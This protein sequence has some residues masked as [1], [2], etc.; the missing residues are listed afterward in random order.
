MDMQ[1]DRMKGWFGRARINRRIWDQRS[2]V[3][4]GRRG[5]EGVCDV[6]LD[7]GK[8]GDM[9][10]EDAVSGIWKHDDRNSWGKWD[11]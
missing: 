10:C 5:Y 1:G 11:D 3:C 8:G 4:C 6:F 7:F 9:R 2:N